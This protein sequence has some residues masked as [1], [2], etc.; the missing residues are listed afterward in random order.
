ME[1][2]YCHDKLGC[3]RLSFDRPVLMKQRVLYYNTLMCMWV[4]LSV[5]CVHKRS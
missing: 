3:N 1:S 5:A 2:V 4:H